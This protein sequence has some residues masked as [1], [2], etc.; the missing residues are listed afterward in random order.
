MDDIALNAAQ[1]SPEHDVHHGATSG[2]MSLRKNCQVVWQDPC[3][4]TR[5]GKV[6]SESLGS[7]FGSDE[8]V[9]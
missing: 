5:C 9:P 7:A 2:S 1:L 3:P 4:F 8:F 6:E